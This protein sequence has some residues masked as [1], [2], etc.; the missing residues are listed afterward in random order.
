LVAPRDGWPNPAAGPS[1]SG[2]DSV[3]KAARVYDTLADAAYDCALVLATTVRRRELTKPVMTP[4]AG[5]AAIQATAGQAAIVF[6]PERAGLESEDVALARAILTIPVNP[7]FGSLNLAQAVLVCAYEWSRGGTQV[8]TPQERNDPPAPQA[9]LEGMIGQITDMLTA[10]HY[11]F[12]EARATA[13]HRSLRGLLTQ[14]GWSAQQV[15]TLRGV[16][17]TLA[18]KPR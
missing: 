5:M 17:T 16:L 11:F 4:E 9:D 1:A 2:A 14:P 3:L 13:M 6:G 12:P 18:K 10:R 8:S 15:R 7:D